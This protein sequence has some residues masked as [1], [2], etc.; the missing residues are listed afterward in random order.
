MKN[1][2]PIWISS[3]LILSYFVGLIS[4]NILDVSRGI[5][6]PLNPISQLLGYFNKSASTKDALFK[7]FVMVSNTCI[8]LPINLPFQ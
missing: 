5:E 3:L 6:P 4:E 2:S 1:N 8:D 7:S